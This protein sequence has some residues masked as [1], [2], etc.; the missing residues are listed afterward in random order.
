M[1]ATPATPV[2]ITPA[3]TPTP[4]PAQINTTYQKAERGK[5]EVSSNSETAEEIAQALDTEAPKRVAR[6]DPQPE[7]PEVTEGE[8]EP[9][10]GNLD[11]NGR[12]HNEDGTFKAAEGKEPEKVAAKPAED[13]KP[14]NSATARV[15]EA[16]RKAAEVKR[17]AAKLQQ[18][19]DEARAELNRLR[20]GSQATAAPIAQPDARSELSAPKEPTPEQFTSYEQFV[21]AR[22]E[23]KARQTYEQLRNQERQQAMSQQRAAALKSIHDGATKRFVDA[24]AANPRYDDPEI[25]D[26]LSK[27]VP[28]Y[29][30]PK[31]TPLGGHNV[32]A[33]AII[34]SA[35]GPAMALHLAEP[36]N[37]TELQRIASLRTPEE[38]L[39][40]MAKLEARLEPGKPAATTA[41][42]A[43]KPVSAARPP[44]RPV[45]GAPTGVEDEEPQEGDV[46]LSKADFAK[47]KQRLRASRRRH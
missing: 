1:G 18:E 21:D 46:E 28:S 29:T 41:A 17:E 20:A 15:E 38:I 39:W 9:T 12:E 35:V 45:T 24:R 16:T 14:R 25:Q 37:R 33:D 4:K 44:V 23:W 7:E 19:R 34:K 5:F 32:I 3:P 22:A 27:L 47:A 30:V 13:K 26:V 36:E 2:T 40:E 10:E 31:G 6:F 8:G 42:T 43:A 11:K